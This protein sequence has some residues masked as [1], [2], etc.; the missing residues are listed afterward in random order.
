MHI[1]GMIPGRSGQW[2]EDVG[3]KFIRPAVRIGRAG[4]GRIDIGILRSKVITA[5]IRSDNPEPTS[6]WKPELL[7]AGSA[8]RQ[9]RR[10]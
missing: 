4:D 3:C 2:A 1:G 9:M 10:G 6:S 7:C 5:V 8:M